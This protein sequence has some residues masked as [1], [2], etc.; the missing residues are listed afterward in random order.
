MPAPHATAL[1]SYLNGGSYPPHVVE[2]FQWPEEMLG[3]QAPIPSVGEQAGESLAAVFG[4]IGGDI[5]TLQS[6][7][8]KNAR[9]YTLHGMLEFWKACHNMGKQDLVDRVFPGEAPN[10]RRHLINSLEECRHD[11]AKFMGRLDQQKQLQLLAYIFD[12]YDSGSTPAKLQ[13]AL[14][15]EGIDL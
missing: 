1:A 12:T 11:I 2:G 13:E 10:I 8:G 3:E 9:L 5:S 6:Q 15:A 7:E 4:Q 14:E